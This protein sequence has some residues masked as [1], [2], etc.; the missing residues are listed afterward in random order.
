[1]EGVVKRSL[2]FTSANIGEK[3]YIFLSFKEF[4]DIFGI[5]PLKKELTVQ[6][7][8]LSVNELNEKAKK[9]LFYFSEIEKA[10]QEA[11]TNLLRKGK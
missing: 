6:M 10:F 9:L 7:S 5:E 4:C 2:S 11:H 3:G 1:L 8:G